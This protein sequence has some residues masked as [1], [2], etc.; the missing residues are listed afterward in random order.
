MIL[1]DKF[2]VYATINETKEWDMQKYL[3]N[4]EDLHYSIEG[5]CPYFET[6][7]PMLDQVT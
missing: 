1:D 5:D 4:G 2:L 3:F 7:D 6:Q